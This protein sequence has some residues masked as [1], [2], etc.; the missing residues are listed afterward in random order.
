MDSVLDHLRQPDDPVRH[1]GRRH[2]EGGAGTGPIGVRGPGTADADRPAALER[3]VEARRGRHG[4]RGQSGIRRLDLS[5]PRAD[6]LR[7]LLDPELQELQRLQL[8]RHLSGGHAAQRARRDPRGRRHGLHHDRA[9]VHQGLHALPRLA[10]LSPRQQHRLHVQPAAQRSLEPDLGAGD[11][12]LQL[13]AGRNGHQMGVRQ[14]LGRRGRQHE[15]RRQHVGIH[16]SHGRSLV[17]RAEQ[18]RRPWPRRAPGHPSC[19]AGRGSGG[20]RR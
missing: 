20:S 16:V 1:D 12:G 7:P 11:V 5:A 14:L 3:N 13:R 8:H 6:A 4:E 9:A 10:G 17:P 15:H 19:S 2:A 18:R